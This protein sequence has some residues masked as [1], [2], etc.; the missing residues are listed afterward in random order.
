MNSDLE[1]EKRSPQGH[2]AP[3]EV[4]EPV[5]IGMSDIIAALR[6]GWRDFL[7]APAFGLFFAG[8]YV[9]GGLVMAAVS[10]AAGEEWWLIPFVVGFPLIAP[11]AAVGL[12]DVSRRIEEA[13]PLIW[14]EILATVFAQK[15]RQVPSMAMVVLLLFMFWV[16]VAHTI[17]A[18][19]LGTSA[20]TNI[21]SSPDILMQGRGL[22]MLLTGGVIGAIFAAALFSFTV[23]GLPLILDREVD[24]ITAIITS[25]RAVMLNPVILSIWGAMVAA[26]LIVGMAPFFI[27]LLVVLPVLGHASWHIY[28]RLMPDE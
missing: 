26:L 19:F 5:V 8:F 2:D 16:F 15:D 14:R 22:A 18:L 10:M 28:R 6:A 9:M 23:V 7:C 24:F 27:G 13:E 20:L 12:Y 21:T 11:F 4:P 1:P 25:I 3:D 17:F